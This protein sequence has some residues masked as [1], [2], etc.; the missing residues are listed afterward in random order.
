[1]LEYASGSSAP[2]IEAIDHARSVKLEDDID[3]FIANRFGKRMV[4]PIMAIHEVEE[5]RPIETA[6][7]VTVTAT[8][9]AQSIPNTDRR[10]EVE[11]EA[12]QLLQAA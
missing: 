1:L 12:G 10:L 3:A 5:G 4:A 9:H 11:R 6:W 7:D 2:V 8:A